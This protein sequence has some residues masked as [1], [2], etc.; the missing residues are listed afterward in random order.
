M[1][2]FYN[3][4]IYALKPLKEKIN[5]K[6]KELQKI[7]IKYEKA[8]TEKRLYDYQDMILEVIK[9]LESNKDLLC[10]FGIYNV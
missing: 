7:Y 2:L 10:V 5:E 6:N 3:Y 9:A 1:N 4:K 8:L